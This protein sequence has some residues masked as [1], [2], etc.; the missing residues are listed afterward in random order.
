MGTWAVDAFG[1][2]DAADWASELDGA[3][4]LDPL[5]AAI[6]RVL[7]Y[8]DDY[9]EAPDATVALAAIDV[10]ACLLGR[11]ATKSAYPEGVERWVAESE[12]VPPP[13]L[14][15][16]SLA[17]IARILGEN[18]E[19]KELWEDSDD[20]DDWLAAMADLRARLTD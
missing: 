1:N 3:E 20:H 6:E 18:S 9:L 10:L 8:G 12:L 7:E 19:L 15:E 17:V 11:P 16:Q 14:V 13:E 4:D 2:D 5:A